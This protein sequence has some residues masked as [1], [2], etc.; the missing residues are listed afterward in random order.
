MSVLNIWKIGF[1]PSVTKKT[2]RLRHDLAAQGEM[3]TYSG[4]AYRRGAHRCAA[5]FE[6]CG[7]L[8]AL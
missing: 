4:A 5:Q 6:C 3:G 1:V 8:Y 2:S 7:Y